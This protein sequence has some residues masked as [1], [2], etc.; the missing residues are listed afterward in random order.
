MVGCEE[1]PL[2]SHHLTT[3][4]LQG[5]CLTIDTFDPKLTKP[6]KA[7]LAPLLQ[8]PCP[9]HLT[10]YIHHHTTCNN[11]QSLSPSTQDGYIRIEITEGN[12]TH[13]RLQGNFESDEEGMVE[14]VMERLGEELLP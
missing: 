9:R 11:P 5:G 4:N 12:T 14:R 3:Q 2:Y 7:T 10:G 8:A 1:R 6:L 13:Y